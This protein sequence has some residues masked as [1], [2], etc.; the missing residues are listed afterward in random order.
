MTSEVASARAE[1]LGRGHALHGSVRRRSAR[2]ALRDER[3]RRAAEAAELDQEASARPRRTER[4]ATT[5]PGARRAGPSRA[6]GWASPRP[7]SRR[8]CSSPARPTDGRPGNAPTWRLDL[9]RGTAIMAASQGSCRTSRSPSRPRRRAIRR[10]P[11]QCSKPRLSSAPRE[12]AG[13]SRS[14]LPRRAS[15]T[16]RQAGTKGSRSLRPGSRSPRRPGDGQI[17]PR[18]AG[19]RPASKR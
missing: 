11:S 9:S 17:Q 3:L 2:R 10:P 13:C 12:T 19:P 15:A 8:S 1:R 7:R 16:V 4:I 6:V 14:S 5:S 18:R